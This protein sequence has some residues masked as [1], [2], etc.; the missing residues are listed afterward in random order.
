MKFSAV[1]LLVLLAIFHLASAQFEDFESGSHFFSSG[2]QSGLSMVLMR[3]SVSG[4]DYQGGQRGSL[5]PGTHP[6][7]NCC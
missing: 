2:V 1:T 3:G 6:N 7:V 5:S 4:E